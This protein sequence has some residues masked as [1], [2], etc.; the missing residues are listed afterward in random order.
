MSSDTVVSSLGPDQLM[1]ES[2]DGV[3]EGDGKSHLEASK[4]SEEESPLWKCLPSGRCSQFSLLSGG[5]SEPGHIRFSEEAVEV[6][7]SVD[8]LRN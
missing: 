4:A 1:V 7:V 3:T 5:R 2:S 6:A 8:I